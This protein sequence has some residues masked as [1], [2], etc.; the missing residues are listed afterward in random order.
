MMAADAGV[1]PPPLHTPVA[2]NAYVS[3]GHKLMK[4]ERTP[5]GRFRISGTATP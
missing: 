5:A 4:V 3:P 1:A 2:V